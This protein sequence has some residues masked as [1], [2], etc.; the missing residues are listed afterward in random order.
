MQAVKY[1]S[2]IVLLLCLLLSMSVS[3]ATN[4]VEVTQLTSLYT[5]AGHAE[6]LEDKT[7]QYQTPSDIE[8]LD[9]WSP[10][11]RE[12]V[13]QGASTSTFWLRFSIKNASSEPQQ[14]L[15]F[16]P[17][18]FQDYM[19]VYVFNQQQS[20]FYPT[21]SLVPF[22]ERIHSYERLAV[23]HVI[24]ANSNET[25]YIR[26]ANRFVEHNSLDVRLYKSDVFKTFVD[27]QLLT[28]GISFGLLFA[29]AIVW[30]IFAVTLKQQRLYL[31]F[32][33]S[34]MTSMTLFAISG[35]GFKYIYPNYP[36]IH[37]RFF[38]SGIFLTIALSF[39]FTRKHLRLADNGITFWNKLLG[40]LALFCIGTAFFSAAGLNHSAA[41]LASMVCLP[42]SALNIV[43]AIKAWQKKPE[44]YVL[45]YISAWLIMAIAFCLLGLQAISG[46]GSNLISLYTITD[47]IQFLFVIE[48][49]FLSISL[50]QWMRSQEKVRIAAEHDAQHDPLTNLLNRRAFEKA[51]TSALEQPHNLNNVWL[52]LIDIDHFKHINDSYGHQAGDAVLKHISDLFKLHCRSDD[53]ICR[54]GG[55]EFALLLTDVDEEGATASLNRLLSRFTDSSTTFENKK[56]H[57]TFSAGVVNV[58]TFSD[59]SAIVQQ[60]DSLLYRA[61]QN[62]RN[63]IV[64][65]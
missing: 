53:L 14:W 1:F 9:T 22:N 27:K 55:E 31:Y 57:H 4:A 25:V 38:I 18:T 47:N 20:Y 46:I 42:F 29:M 2:Q 45:W 44:Q 33:F 62:G 43:I 61:K 49:L 21:S 24:P 28:N 64:F 23:K 5:L 54:Y 63:Q 13:E 26:L 50:A 36:I 39:L 51:I 48:S 32:A 52:A 19:D 11:T 30:L 35:Y 56:I 40:H 15:V 60:A 10:L 12:S 37:D 41:V 3:S 65:V 17:Q 34:V 58:K 16:H 8:H 7:Q 59:Y 6:Y